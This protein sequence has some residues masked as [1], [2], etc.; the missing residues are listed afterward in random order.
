MKCY[1]FIFARKGS[2]RLKNKN[3][4]ILNKNLLSPIVL[5]YQKN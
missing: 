2:K 1:A 5:T 3:L 4:K